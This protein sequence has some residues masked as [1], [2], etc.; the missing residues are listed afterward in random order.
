MAL[1]PVFI[2]HLSGYNEQIQEYLNL[3]SRFP[4]RNS[5]RAPLESY[6]KLCRL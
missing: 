6:H 2:Q 5:Y 4:G 1:F 3:C